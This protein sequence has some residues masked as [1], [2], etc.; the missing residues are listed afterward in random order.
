M[1]E[2]RPS[3]E[4]EKDTPVP[5]GSD[6]E[7]SRRSAL[8]LG[9]G[10]AGAASL[11]AT[12]AASAE[13]GAAVPQVL[14][15]FAF[16]AVA[17]GASHPITAGDIAA[18]PQ[19]IGRYPIG[20]EWDTVAVQE[21]LYAA[22]AGASR[23]GQV[24]WNNAEPA[25]WR[26]RAIRIPAGRYRIDRTLVCAM[27]GFQILGDGRQATTL[28]W[29]G[30][31]DSPMW[32]CDSAS[33]GVFGDLCLEAASATSQALLE[34]DASGANKGLKTQQVTLRDMTFACNGVAAIGLRISK[35]GGA[36][37]GDTILIDNCLFGGA[38]LAG[39]AVGE[40]SSQNALGITVHGG[41]FQ[42]CLPHGVLVFGGQV[43]I[44]NTSFQNQAW[45]SPR[46][47]IALGGADVTV[48]GGSGVSGFSA[49][50]NIRSESDVL[51]HA[52]GGM[53]V[54]NASLVC[55]GIPQWWA[56]ARVEVGAVFSGTPGLGKPGQDGRTFICVRAG[57][58]GATEPDWRAVPRGRSIAAGSGGV[59]IAKGAREVSG[60]WST[61]ALSPG[62]VI[63]IPGAG[64]EGLALI[65]E[66]VAVAAGAATLS[67]PAAR[68]VSRS[69]AYL[70]RPITDGAVQWMEVD[71]DSVFGAHCAN[72]SVGA[73]RARNCGVIRNSLFARPD[74][75]RDAQ[76]EPAW[77]FE[78]EWLRKPVT[79]SN[80]QVTAGASN[81]PQVPHHP[82]TDDPGAQ[83]LS[84]S[85]PAPVLVRTA[86]APN[87]ATLD[88]GPLMVMGNLVPVSVSQDMRIEAPSAP[89]GSEMVLLI[90][91]SAA[92][93]TVSFGGNIRAAGPLATGGASK[94]FSLRL[95]SDGTAWFEVSRAGPL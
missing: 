29:S 34:L 89:P 22:F 57:V 87:T 28:L 75:L 82:F 35:S 6:R 56:S 76:A 45:N 2:P 53:H 26:N 95:V 92:G 85:L 72:L 51:V 8:L 3:G 80:V 94:S 81:Q 24:A 77:P 11:T 4:I 10:L 70:G 60:K 30:P 65:A 54:D 23:P 50:R 16:G 74:W 66:V 14:T 43:F 40:T 39:L 44:D 86:A 32:L 15:P 78:I 79:V 20:A 52:E 55:A 38:S 46:N 61:A 25:A 47:Q 59:A 27:M 68:G 69:M 37:Q 83:V 12:K 58:T 67:Q 84:F 19:W 17:D 71:Y 1:A 90:T 49:M 7:P 91:G 21:C 9:A 36:A 93:H 5:A 64:A 13:L 48:R 18:N 73:G 33:Y 42:A 41:D 31:A 63:V 88:L 62:D